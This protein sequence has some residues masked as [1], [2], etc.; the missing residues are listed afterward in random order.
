MR[1]CNCSGKCGPQPLQLTRREFMEVIG[2]SAGAALMATPVW[3]A[4]ELAPDEF[5]RWRH[6]LLAQ[7][8]P[9]ASSTD[10]EQYAVSIAGGALAF[11]PKFVLYGQDPN[12]KRWQEFF[13]ARPELAGW[14]VKKLGSFG[15]V[16]PVV[17]ENPDVSFHASFVKSRHNRP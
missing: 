14:Q 12:V 1:K 17:F 4:F 9:Y 7:G 5:E 8:Q 2:A 15:D 13:S 16:A 3:G 6:D 11:S 10:A